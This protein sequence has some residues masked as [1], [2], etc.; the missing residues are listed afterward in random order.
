M[1]LPEVSVAFVGG[2]VA[3]RHDQ[4][5]LPGDLVDRLHEEDGQRFA[6]G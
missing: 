4:I 3:I 6:G 2:E 5:V 1:E